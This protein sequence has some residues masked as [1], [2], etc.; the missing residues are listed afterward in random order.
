[1]TMEIRQNVQESGVYQDFLV[2]WSNK[3]AGPSAVS[4]ISCPISISPVCI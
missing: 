2:T 1:M 4:S 3:N